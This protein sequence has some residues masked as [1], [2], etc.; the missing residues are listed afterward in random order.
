MLMQTSANAAALIG[1]W[2]GF[3]P[4][5]YLD[6]LPKPPVWTI[7]KGTTRYHNGDM[8]QPG[9]EITENEA[10]EEVY[11]FIRKQIE[12]AGGKHFASV[13]LQPGMRDALASLMYNLINGTNPDKSFPKTKALILASAPIHDILDEWVT[14]IY[15]GGEPH[16]GLHRRRVCEALVCLGWPYDQAYEA[17]KA[18]PLEKGWRDVSGYVEPEPEEVLEIPRMNREK[19]SDPTPE[20]GKITMDDAQ[21]LSAEAAGYDGTYEEFMAHRT[22]VTAKN[23]IKTPNLDTRRA[24]KPMEDSK[25]FSG[26]SKKESGKEAIQWSAVLS[27][28]AG[29]V[30]VV[31]GLTQNTADTVEAAKPLVVGF[32]INHLILVGLTIGLSLAVIGAYRMIRGHYMAKDGRAEGVQPKV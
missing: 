11:W 9:D 22:V 24:P 1:A 14:A 7:G 27:G 3:K 16:L 23:A 12:P 13:S 26:L 29:T 19:G 31:K 20:D 30:G 15:S 8:V 5:A 2:E 10:D 18:I 32:N 28:T 17:T 4:Q 25:T 6:T 21:F